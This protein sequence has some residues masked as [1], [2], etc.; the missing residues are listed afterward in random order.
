MMKK[1]AP[2]FIL[3]SRLRKLRTVNV[4]DSHSGI[5]CWL[6]LCQCPFHLRAPVPQNATVYNSSSSA[7]S[8]Q[9]SL[10]MVSYMCLCSERYA[11]CGW[12]SRWKMCYRNEKPPNIVAILKSAMVRP[13]FWCVELKH[14]YHSCSPGRSYPSSTRLW[15]VPNWASFWRVFHVRAHVPP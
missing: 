6:R 4:E 1:P 15:M 12:L 14:L 10:R 2:I 13:K 3:C 9:Y 11:T 7:R 8:Q 5:R